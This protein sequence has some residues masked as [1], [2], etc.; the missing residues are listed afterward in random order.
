MTHIAE[1]GAQV[2]SIMPDLPEFVAKAA[3]DAG[4][5]FPVLSDENNG[6]ALSLDLVIWLGERIRELDYSVGVRLEESQK[7]GAWFVPIPATFVI[8]ADGRVIARFLDPD[9]RKRMEI[10]DILDALKRAWILT[11]GTAGLFEFRPIRGAQ[12]FDERIGRGGSLPAGNRI[13]ADRAGRREALQIQH[14][15]IQVLNRTLRRQRVTQTGNKQCHQI[16]SR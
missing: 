13:K 10:D 16:A 9:F 3:R 8:G 2:V 5:A 14:P 6:Y 7:N 1:S 15:D 4:N 12:R 11:S